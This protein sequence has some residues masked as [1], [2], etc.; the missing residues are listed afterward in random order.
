MQCD[1][2]MHTEFGKSLLV[3]FAVD[4]LVLLGLGLLSDLVNSC[5]PAVTLGSESLELVLVAVDLEGEFTGAR[6]LDVLGVGLV[7][8]VSILAAC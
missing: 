2:E 5:E 3:A 7:Q 6:G 4:N 1:G 8:A